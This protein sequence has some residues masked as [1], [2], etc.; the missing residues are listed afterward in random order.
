M[1]SAWS[2]CVP[3]HPDPP[4]TT[5]KRE[6]P[7]ILSQVPGI[8]PSKAQLCNAGVCVSPVNPTG[9]YHLLGTVNRVQMSMLLDTGA[10][11]TLLR[12]DTWLHVAAKN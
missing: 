3:L 10:A 1:P 11:V 5:G 2:Y 7:N 6:T 12:Q 9:G 4:I 8:K